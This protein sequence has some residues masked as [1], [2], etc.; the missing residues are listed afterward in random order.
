MAVSLSSCRNVAVFL[1]H[2]A[3]KASISL[4]LSQWRSVDEILGLMKNEEFKEK[5]A[6]ELADVV[7]FG[8]IFLSSLL[9]ERQLALSRRT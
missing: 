4:E 7:I 5:I 9:T 2:P 8:S 3:I 1:P 6:E